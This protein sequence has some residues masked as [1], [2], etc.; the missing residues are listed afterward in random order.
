[1]FLVNPAIPMPI[2]HIK[3]NSV[4]CQYKSSKNT[5]IIK[6]VFFFFIFW[7]RAKVTAGVGKPTNAPRFIGGFYFQ[8]G[9]TTIG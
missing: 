1:M 9:L 8:Q 3:S 5:V 6:T 2:N 4:L 7:N